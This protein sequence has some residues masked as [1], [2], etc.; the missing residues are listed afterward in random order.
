MDRQVACGEPRPN[1]LPLENRSVRGLPRLMGPSARS[2][3]TGART[4]APTSF[5]WG[6]SPRGRVNLLIL[7]SCSSRT[8]LVSWTRR[9]DATRFALGN[10]CPC[11]ATHPINRPSR[12]PTNQTEILRS[13]SRDGAGVEEAASP[14][15][16][17]GMGMQQAGMPIGQIGGAEPDLLPRAVT[18]RDI[19][20]SRHKIEIWPRGRTGVRSVEESLPSPPPRGAG[21]RNSAC[22]NSVCARRSLCRR[23][24]ALI[25]SHYQAAML[26]PSPASRINIRSSSSVILASR[27][28]SSR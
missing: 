21:P 11:P 1:H 3:Y 12:R 9:D 27:R 28:C 16:E 13:G 25:I 18:T 26:P 17:P 19:R 7:C 6:C 23:P 22:R 14:N 2:I 8:C 4:P 24:G 10:L 5:W 15:A 20:T